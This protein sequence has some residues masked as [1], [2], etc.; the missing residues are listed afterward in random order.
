MVTSASDSK[1]LPRTLEQ[2]E[3]GKMAQLLKCLLSRHEGL[4][5]Y[6][7]H[8]CKYQA[9]P[10]MPVMSAMGTGEAL[11]LTHLAKMTSSGFN[12]TLGKNKADKVKDT[13]HR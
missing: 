7:Q 12:E 2:T 5:S 11:K 3:T 6:P 10:C 8:P 9:R 13:Q 1:T 4:T